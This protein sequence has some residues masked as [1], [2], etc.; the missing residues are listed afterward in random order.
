MFVRIS[1]DQIASFRD[2]EDIMAHGRIVRD[3]GES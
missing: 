3:E 1:L 2:F